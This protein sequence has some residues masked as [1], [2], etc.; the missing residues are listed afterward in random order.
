[1]KSD[2]KL[3]PAVPEDAAALLEIYAPYVLNTSISFE[4]EV[5]S[6]EEFTER[7]RDYSAK[8]PYLVAERNGRIA[9][10]AYAHAYGVRAA[11]LRTVELSIYLRMDERGA[12]IGRMLYEELE[13]ILKLQNVQNMVAIITGP[14]SED[15]P[16]SNNDSPNF[17]RRMGFTKVG[18]LH[19]CGYKFGRWYN[20]IYAE[21]LIG[22][23]EEEPGPFRT[24]E[25]VRGSLNL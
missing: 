17:H 23:H 22:N 24:F 20:I 11:Y 6:V 10:Y 9:G 5:P 2:V 3:R 15:D 16:Y 14:Q 25:E 18:E 8:Y 21:K 1:M 13:R 12:G 7:I 19:K 4:Y